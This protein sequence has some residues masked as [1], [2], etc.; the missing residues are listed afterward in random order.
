MG[1]WRSDHLKIVYMTPPPYKYIGTVQ[2]KEKTDEQNTTEDRV[3]LV[4]GAKKELKCQ[5]ELRNSFWMTFLIHGE[6]NLLKTILLR[7]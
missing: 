7:L 1:V 3:V 6:G 4:A 5:S 2:R